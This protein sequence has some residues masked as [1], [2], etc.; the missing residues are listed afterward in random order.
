MWPLRCL[1]WWYDG[2]GKSGSE[3]K[4]LLEAVI[5]SNTE[6]IDQQD[7]IV[8]ITLDDN[9]LS[10]DDVDTLN[11]EIEELIDDIDVTSI[12]SIKSTYKS[13]IINSITIKEE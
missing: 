8:S 3:V 6:H 4:T 11:E 1:G 12:Y 9:K 13:G 7:L 10:S 2:S 5:S